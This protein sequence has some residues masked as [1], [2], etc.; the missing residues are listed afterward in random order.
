MITVLNFEAMLSL[1]VRL[2]LGCRHFA[3]T[4]SRAVLLGNESLQARYRTIIHC[5]LAMNVWALGA[6]LESDHVL[7]LSVHVHVFN[8]PSLHAQSLYH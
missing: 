4:Q 1:C 7:F 3:P 5:M 2:S 8:V 6:I